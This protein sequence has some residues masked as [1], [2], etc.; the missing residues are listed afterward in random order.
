MK[1]VVR[2]GRRFTDLPVKGHPIIFYI[3]PMIKDPVGSQRVVCLWRGPLA[4]DDKDPVRANERH[5]Y[6]FALGA[7]YDRSTCLF[8][9]V[10]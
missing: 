4:S 10:R 6:A 5:L 2:F 8:A 9:G 7:T 3:E 1:H